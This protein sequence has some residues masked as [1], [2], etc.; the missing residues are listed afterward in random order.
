MGDGPH[1]TLLR[2]VAVEVKEVKMSEFWRTVGAMVLGYFMYLG[3]RSILR[4]K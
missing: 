2:C 1:G 4:K 3:L